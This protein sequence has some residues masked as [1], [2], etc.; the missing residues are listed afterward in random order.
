MSFIKCMDQDD[1][2]VLDAEDDEIMFDYMGRAVIVKIERRPSI[3]PLSRCELLRFTLLKDMDRYHQHCYVEPNEIEAKLSAERLK[4]ALQPLLEDVMSEEEPHRRNS[5]RNLALATCLYAEVLYYKLRQTADGSAY[6]E[7]CEVQNIVEPTPHVVKI[8][9]RLPH[10]EARHLRVKTDSI[11]LNRIQATL[12]IPQQHDPT[13]LARYT[14]LTSRDLSRSR[15]PRHKN[16]TAVW[17]DA[18]VSAL[19]RANVG[20]ATLTPE[21]REMLRVPRLIGLVLHGPTMG[22]PFVG[23]VLEHMEAARSWDSLRMCDHPPSK[24]LQTRWARQICETILILHDMGI[25]WGGTVGVSFHEPGS[26]LLE[27]VDIDTN[28]QPWLVR[29]FGGRVCQDAKDADLAASDGL[30]RLAEGVSM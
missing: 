14:V 26:V 29:N 12:T 8:Q 6:L 5:Q 3:I 4:A 27:G 2:T 20:R 11:S 7:E 24:E 15:L 13:R 22:R 30:M 1:V 19:S 28:D 16:N 23:T 25:V 10:F 18:M 21:Q 17:L 9:V